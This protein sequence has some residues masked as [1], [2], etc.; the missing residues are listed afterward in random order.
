MVHNPDF[1]PFPGLH[2]K[3]FK[4][5]A[6]NVAWRHQNCICVCSNLQ[7]IDSGFLDKGQSADRIDCEGIKLCRFLSAAAWS[8]LVCLTPRA[9]VFVKI[10]LFW[11]FQWG[12]RCES[13]F[14]LL[15]NIFT[16]FW[17]L[18]RHTDGWER[19]RNNR[20][21]CVLF[22]RCLCRSFFSSWLFT[23]LYRKNTFKFVSSSRE[24][25]SNG[26]LKN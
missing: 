26:D 17:K 23:T 5:F 8:S 9:F 6:N 1:K 19:K 16:V 10:R 13:R 11:I 2:K 12:L 22:D 18:E 15:K 4:M 25:T 20:S 7:W 21:G 3:M 14:F 24:I